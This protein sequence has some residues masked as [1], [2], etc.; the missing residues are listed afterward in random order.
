M[1]SIGSF[2]HVVFNVKVF[3]SRSGGS[4]ENAFVVDSAAADGEECFLLQHQDL[5]HATKESARGF[6]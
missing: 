1:L 3:H 5:L 2:W 6:V 4:I